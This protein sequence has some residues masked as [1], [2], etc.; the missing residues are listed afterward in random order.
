[1]K[2]ALINDLHVIRLR[3][4]T[5]AYDTSDHDTILRKSKKV[6]DY[7]VILLVHIHPPILPPLPLRLHQ[8]P[9]VDEPGT[10]LIFHLPR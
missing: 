1:M 7:N 8:V 5:Y 10:R 4:K 6:F 9:H 2:E 3:A